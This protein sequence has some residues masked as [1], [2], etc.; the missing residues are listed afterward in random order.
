[1]KL[2]ASR[3][4]GIMGEKI[5]NKRSTLWLWEGRGCW[6]AL[7]LRALFFKDAWMIMLQLWVG[8]NSGH[9]LGSGWPNLCLCN[10]AYRVA[11]GSRTPITVWLQIPQIHV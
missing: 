2:N 10:F 7:A 9:S 5:L 1:M 4:H 11:V 8:K 3:A 6:L